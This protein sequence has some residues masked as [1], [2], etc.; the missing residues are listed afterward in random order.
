MD[1]QAFLAY[2]RHLFPNKNLRLLTEYLRDREDIWV[3][4]FC[5]KQVE[6][7]VYA[8]GP[9][10][11]ADCGCKGSTACCGHEPYQSYD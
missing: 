4:E 10:S 1:I 9:C 6:K 2:I 11:I 5:F 7:Q 3:C 8:C